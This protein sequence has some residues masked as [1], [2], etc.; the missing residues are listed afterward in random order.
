MP[1]KIAVILP[2]MLGTL[3][4]GIDS[5]IVN[6]SLPVMRKEFGVGLNDVE[7][8]ITAYMLGFCVFM[9][10]I[11]WLKNRIGFYALYLISLSVFIL[12]SLCC[13][14]SH[15]LP[16]LI[17]SR[18]LQA[19]GGG[20]IAPTAMAILSDTFPK[21]ER[22][23]VMGWWALGS[24]TGPAM[25]PTLGGIL[26]HY[27]G[28][29]SIFLVNL[30]IGVIAIVLAAVS[31]RF[32]KDEPI[33][34]PVFDFRGFVFFTG[35][36]LL[37]QYGFVEMGKFGLSSMPLI[38]TVLAAFACLALFIHY[39]RHNKGSLFN[40][41]I[42]R[43]DTFVRTSIITFV[44]A[45]ALYGG[46]FLLPFLLQGILHF[47]EVESGL[48]ILPNSIMMAIFT[49]LAGNWSD[50]RGPRHIVIAG[51][52]LVAFSMLLFSQADGPYV[53]YILLAMAIRGIGMGFLVSTITSTSL[54]AV[55]PSET[56]SA[57]SMYSLLQQ[58]GGSTGIALSGV[59]HQF[60][61][62]FYRAKGMPDLLAEHHAIEDVFI[63]SMFLVLVAIVP[64]LK[65]PFGSQPQKNNA[66]NAVAVT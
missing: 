4:S 37:F 59:T 55:L 21:A 19:M 12:G 57:S 41:S 17:A 29:P 63:I 33:S 16:H 52:S 46:L 18:A 40:L 35:F 61:Y 42:F 22:G 15:T 38:L 10:V 58:L 23:K 36:I 13:G 3:M 7:W 5:S 56:T 32:L 66:F 20:A 1:K 28:W 62:T 26:T 54:N 31:L 14:L 49:P 39:S 65:L 9:P 44:R 6:V 48:L 60:L 30:P 64:A 11:N 45:I 2:L 25:G 24:I 8:V 27:F 47:S 51:L 34:K 53:W 50:K 43:H